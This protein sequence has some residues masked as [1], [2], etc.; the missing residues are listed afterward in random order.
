MY[1]SNPVPL[2]L[3]GLSIS[4]EI[5]HF[6]LLPFIFKKAMYNAIKLFCKKVTFNILLT[7]LQKGNETES[8]TRGNVDYF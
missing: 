8:D 4:K 5:Q 3:T 2:L 7:P 1:P 6:Q